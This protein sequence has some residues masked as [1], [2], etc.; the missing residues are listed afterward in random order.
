MHNGNTYLGWDF[1]L[2]RI[3]IVVPKQL[4]KKKNEEEVGFHR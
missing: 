2:Y 4:F 1:E 3:S